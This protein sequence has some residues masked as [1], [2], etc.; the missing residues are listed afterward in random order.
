MDE[1]YWIPVFAR[2]T[3]ESLTL[4]SGGIM[5]TSDSLHLAEHLCSRLC[6]DLITPIGAINTGLE[7][8]QENPLNRVQFF[9]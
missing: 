8:L 1:L 2:M 7:L 3:L 9:E 5:N 6:H 4:N